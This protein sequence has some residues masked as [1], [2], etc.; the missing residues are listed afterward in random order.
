MA[1]VV[2]NAADNKASAYRPIIWDLTSNRTAY[3]SRGVTVVADDGGGFAE[4]TVGGAHTYIV[5]DIITGTA[6][7]TETTYNA[8]AEVTGITGT[9]I[10]TDLAFTATDVG[11]A[12]RTND[13]FKTK[14][15]AYTYASQPNPI[16]SAASEPDLNT[17]IV[18]T[19]DHGLNAGDWVFIDSTTS[20]NG[21]QQLLTVPTTDSYVIGVTF[22]ATETGNSRNLH[23][24]GSKAV[25]QITVAGDTLF[26][27]NV[28]SFMKADLSYDIAA[29]GGVTDIISPNDN[30]EVEYILEWVEVYNDK[31]GIPQ[32]VDTTSITSGKQ[33]YNTALQHEEPQNLTVFATDDSTKRFLTNIPDF[34]ILRDDEEIQL[35]FITFETSLKVRIIEYDALTGGT[36]TVTTSAS[37][38]ITDGRG[39]VTVSGSIYLAS[40]KRI[41]VKLVDNAGTTDLSETRTFKI[42]PSICDKPRLQW[43]NRLG[44]ID[45]YTFTGDVERKVSAS[46]S[47]FTRGLA[48]GFGVG[49]S[50]DNILG[51]EADNDFSIWT[52]FLSNDYGIWME[53]LIT[54]NKAWRVSGSDQIPIIITRNKATTTDTGSI[55]QINITYQNANALNIQDA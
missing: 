21:I 27:F 52:D 49:D 25:T 33:A 7:A 29:I 15:T 41:E 36:P 50:G 44:G 42:L 28:S 1:L 13:E 3:L 38:T 35:H 20:Y 45:S 24:L 40:T 17:R 12:T 43:L 9:T 51:V 11:I 48:V 26:R 5:G 2:L 16:L 47:V 39:I 22:V 53:E 37:K 30:S 10:V 8:R 23:V 18:L 46:K 19:S 31:A 54:S 32:E 55:K 14:V 6:F 4:M 34:A